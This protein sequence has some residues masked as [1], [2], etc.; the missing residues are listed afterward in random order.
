MNLVQMYQLEYT[1]KD[2]PQHVMKQIAGIENDRMSAQNAENIG[3]AEYFLNKIEYEGKN[4]I[5]ELGMHGASAEVTENV[6]KYVKHIHAACRDEI[7]S[8][9]QRP[10]LDD[11]EVAGI[12]W[13]DVLSKLLDDVSKGQ[14]VSQSDLESALNG[15]RLMVDVQSKGQTNDDARSD[16]EDMFWF[17]AADYMRRKWYLYGSVMP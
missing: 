9:F 14:E 12:L 5:R 17:Y 3:V 11:G 6:A 15:L 2:V 1:G 7:E 4:V 10:M 8:R 16:I 13:D